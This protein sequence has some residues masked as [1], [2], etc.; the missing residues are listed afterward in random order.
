MAEKTRIAGDERQ[1]AIA[2][3][4]IFQTLRWLSASRE[5][6]R[7]ASERMNGIYFPGSR[8]LPLV[9][10]GSRQRIERVTH[11]RLF[12]L[13]PKETHRRS[14]LARWPQPGLPA[15]GVA[16]DRFSNWLPCKRYWPKVRV[17][18]PNPNLLNCPRSHS[19]EMVSRPKHQGSFLRYCDW[20]R[21]VALPTSK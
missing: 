14:V 10:I 4:P 19:A 20:P 17:Q 1:I 9:G 3:P 7:L 8:S 11:Q 12:R 2:P 18:K 6:K 15:N 16:E 21:S 13:A 5:L